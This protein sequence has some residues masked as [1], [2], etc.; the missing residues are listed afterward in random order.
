MFFGPVPIA[1]A[2]GALLAHSVRAGKVRMKKGRLLTEAD[3]AT[4]AAAGVTEVT[5]ARL[6]P[7][8]MGE[9]EAA[10]LIANA[11]LGSGVRANAP[12]TGRVNLFAE[13]AGVLTL[14]RLR[15]ERINLVDE[16]A[17]VATLEPYSSVEEGQ[18]VA[19][20]KIIPFAASEAVLSRIEKIAGSAREKLVSVAP[21]KPKRVALVQSTL[22]SV[23]PS[24]LDKTVDITRERL[25]PLGATL[26]SERR[27]DH[28]IDA[29]AASL[30]EAL[31]DDPDIVLIAGASAIVDRR[32][33]LPGGVVDAGGRVI[34][35]GMPVDPGNLILMGEVDGLPVVGLPGCAR[36]PKLNGFDWVLARLCAD[37]PVGSQEIMGMGAGGLLAEIPTRGHPRAT[38]PDGTAEEAPRAPRI[39]AVVL[40]AGQSRRMGN[41]NKLLQKIDG[42][43]MVAHTLDAVAASEAYTT[44]VVTGHETDTISPLLKGRDVLVVHNP[45]YAEGLSTSLKAGLR[46]LPRDVD[47]VMVCLG[48]MPEVTARHL[49]R[50]IA[51][52][53]P[54][55][56]RAI[57][58]PTFQGQR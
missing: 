13:T 1:D 32:D 9:D 30:R 22:P 10:E 41:I 29:I 47:G 38:Q 43:P 40:A 8:E 49:N 33:A 54:L 28:T 46:S 39:A 15:L 48:D 7:G 55:E 57:V 4:L 31:A 3:V 5:V 51:A 44:V 53:N 17:T 11:L 20:I 42:Q 18:M 37:L 23:K 2:T 58:V 27:C 16:S 24:V 12:F 36:S 26:T 34:H 35:F 6:E 45:D 52:F 56:G 50:L 25:I 21:F 19:T 14:D